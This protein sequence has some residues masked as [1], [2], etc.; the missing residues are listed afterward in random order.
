[1][2]QA[3]TTNDPL[4]EWLDALKAAE[5]FELGQVVATPGAIAALTKAGEHPTI[6]VYRHHKLEQGALSASYHA[7]NKEAL[8][9]GSRV[10]SA[11]LLADG[12]KIWI[13]TEAVG[14]DG[15]RASTCILLPEEY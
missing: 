11:F 4:D 10:F 2:S 7:L 15:K 6:W 12:V 5:K 9:D 1:M 13:I 14:D 8:A 3:T